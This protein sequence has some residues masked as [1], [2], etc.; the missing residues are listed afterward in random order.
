MAVFGQIGEL[1]AVIGE[2][3]VDPVRDRL[4]QGF[5]KSRSGFDIGSLDE[6]GEG[7]LGGAVDGDEEVELALGGAHLGEIDVEVADGILFELLLFGGRRAVEIGQAA[8]AVALEAAMQ[9]GASELRNRGLQRIEAIVER[10]QGV[11]AESHDDGFLL[12]AQRGGARL[13]PHRRV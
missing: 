9:S 11:F 7:E 1:D 5:E 10:Q 13:R 4:D 3:G 12:G 8:D 6:L 2:H